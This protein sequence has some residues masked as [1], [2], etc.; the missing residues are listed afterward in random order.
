MT[1]RNK[2][3]ENTHTNKDGNILLLKKRVST[4]MKYSV[5]KHFT[6][7]SLSAPTKSRHKETVIG[8]NIYNIELI[9]L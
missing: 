1:D 8:F 5:G 2:N 7:E 9:T 4:G 6:V 3:T